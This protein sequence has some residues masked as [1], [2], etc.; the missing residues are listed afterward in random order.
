MSPD[1]DRLQLEAAQS[2]HVLPNASQES[3]LN[4]LPAAY[5]ALNLL[6]KE[7]ARLTNLCTMASERIDAFKGSMSIMRKLPPEIL[8]EIFLYCDAKGTWF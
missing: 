8:G 6:D 5:E 1:W 7:I 3:I 2:N 4:L